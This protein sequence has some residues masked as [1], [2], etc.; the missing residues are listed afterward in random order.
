MRANNY[1]CKDLS[2]EAG[3]TLLTHRGRS[4]HAPEVHALVIGVGDYSY[5]EGGNRPTFVHTGGM[6]QLD[7]PP[8]SAAKFCRWL[9]NDMRPQG[10]TL[11]S[12]EVLCSGPAHFVDDAG[13][14]LTPDRATMSNVKMAA[15]RWYAAV[16]SHPDNLAIFYFCGHGVSS[17][18]VHSLLL[19]D[20][21]SDQLDPFNSGAI[22]AEAFMDGLRQNNACS[23]LFLLDAC[24]TVGH[25]AFGQYG[26][27][28]GTPIISGAPHANLG[29]IHQAALWATALGFKAYGR[30]AKESL[31]MEAMLAS[32]N[33]AGS[34]Q[35]VNDGSWVIQPDM[36]KRGI[37]FFVQRTAGTQIQYATLDR[38]VQGFAV[39]VLAG[40]PVVPV[41]VNCRPADKTDETELRCSSGDIRKAGP[42]YPWHLDL[43]HSQYTFEAVSGL[44]GIVDTKTSHTTPPWTVVALDV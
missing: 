33:G 17:G 23:Q 20:F 15:A 8:I 27:Q 34:M 26:T 38:H 29:T 44:G 4:G 21:G 22:D 25:Q 30:T 11:G 2:T 39:H 1:V 16:N 24:R 12:V 13:H 41:R 32:M 42:S 5:L 6:G 7:S 43:P 14:Q 3:M 9:M 18:D 37:D 35:D 10:K 36:L 28:R 40:D 31:F 19:E